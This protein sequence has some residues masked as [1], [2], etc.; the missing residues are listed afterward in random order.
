MYIFVVHG[1]A[2]YIHVKRQI[3]FI[4]FGIFS[5]ISNFM[6]VHECIGQVDTKEISLNDEAHRCVNDGH[7]FLMSKI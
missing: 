1:Q 5:S 2:R 7:L 4:P 6:Y 3:S